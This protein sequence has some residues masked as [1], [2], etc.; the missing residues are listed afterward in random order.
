MEVCREGQHQ[1]NVHFFVHYLFIM[2]SGNRNGT[3]IVK[4]KGRTVLREGQR[5]EEGR[6]WHKLVQGKG[7]SF[8]SIQFHEKSRLQDDLQLI[9]HSRSDVKEA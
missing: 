6:L 2:L 4:V 1:P 5:K 7:N 8:E 9:T 3:Q